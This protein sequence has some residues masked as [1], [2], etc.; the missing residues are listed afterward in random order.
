[1]KPAKPTAST[2]PIA[3]LRTIVVGRLD[4][5]ISALDRGLTSDD[6]V[7]E[8]RKDL[9]R[10]RALLRLLRGSVGEATYDRANQILRDMGRPLTPIR[11]AEIL[12]R[13]L[14]KVRR[15]KDGQPTN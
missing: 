9:K 6:A 8:L 12:M 14:G 1:M 11:D 7:H 5:V 15:T 4:E 2:G 10:L 3:Q 13:T